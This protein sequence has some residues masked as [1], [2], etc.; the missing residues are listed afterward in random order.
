MVHCTD[1]I[2]LCLHEHDWLIWE[3]GDFC[4]GH[5]DNLTQFHEVI[6]IFN[7]STMSII[8]STQNRLLEFTM[9]LRHCD[10]MWFFY[11]HVVLPSDVYFS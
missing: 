11:H 5:F 7:P 10:N 3:C 1:S 9:K 2:L 6:E 4:S 8:A